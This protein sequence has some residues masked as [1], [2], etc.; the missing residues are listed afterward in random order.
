MKF[1]ESTHRQNLETQ[2]L[3]ELRK[4]LI[5]DIVTIKAKVNE[6]IFF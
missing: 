6:I 1:Q 5:N 3:E 2:I 4:T